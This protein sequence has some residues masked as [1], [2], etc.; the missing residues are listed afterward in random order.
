MK[1]VL[2]VIPATS[3]LYLGFAQIFG[4]PGETLVLAVAAFISLV[5]GLCIDFSS[6]QYELSG[7]AYDG[8]IVVTTPEDGPKLF[9]LQLDCDLETLDQKASIRFKVVP[10]EDPAEE[11]L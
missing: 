2:I 1:L 10:Q 4:L 6:R 3:F 9:S 11:E 5:L 8:Q 7:A